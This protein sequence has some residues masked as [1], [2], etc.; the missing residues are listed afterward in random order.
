MSS[1]Q[2]CER[3]QVCTVDDDDD[4]PRVEVVVLVLI[5]LSWRANLSAGLSRCF[6]SV[7][8]CSAWCA[9]TITEQGLVGDGRGR[10]GARMPGYALSERWAAGMQTVYHNNT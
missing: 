7:V 4:S 10:E 3:I 6:V 8:Y 1:V 9:S 5:R 2:Q